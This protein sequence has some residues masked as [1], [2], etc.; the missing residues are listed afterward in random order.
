MAIKLHLFLTSALLASVVQ[1]T[2]EGAPGTACVHMTPDHNTTAQND[3]PHFTTEPNTVI[4][5]YKF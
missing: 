1:A 2:P 3:F 4:F 5:N